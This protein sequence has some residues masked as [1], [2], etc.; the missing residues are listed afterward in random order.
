VLLK[1][2]SRNTWPTEGESV[3]EGKVGSMLEV[4]AGFHPEFTGREK[5]LPGGSNPGKVG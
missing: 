5:S 2:H 3:L 1:I 4:S